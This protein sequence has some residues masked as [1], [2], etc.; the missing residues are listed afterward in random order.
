MLSGIKTALKVVISWMWCK[1][2]QVKFMLGWY[3]LIPLAN[4]AWRKVLFSYF[5]F[6]KKLP[7]LLGHS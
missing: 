3:P 6:G 7:Y 2:N 5:L 1:K 4:T